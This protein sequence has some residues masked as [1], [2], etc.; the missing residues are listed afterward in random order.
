MHTHTRARPNTLSN[1]NTHFRT[2]HSKVKEG[3]NDVCRVIRR[4]SIKTSNFDQDLL[5]LNP[6]YS[7]KGSLLHDLMNYLVRLENLSGVCVWTKNTSA[8]INTPTSVDLIE[9]QHCRISFYNQQSPGDSALTS[10]AM[11]AKS[12]SNHFVS[13]EH[14][15]L[16][17]SNQGEDI[18]KLL[19][20]KYYLLPLLLLNPTTT[21][22]TT[23][24][25]SSLP[26]P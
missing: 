23:T 15:E 20:G 3:T 13:I 16:F 26:R 22:P 25:H 7:R 4:P 2:T 5:L 12:A 6:L 24:R 9:L 21:S 11:S 10:S 19:Q 14:P 18:E 8:Q 1:N 17:M